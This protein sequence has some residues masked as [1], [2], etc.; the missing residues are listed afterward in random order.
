MPSHT[1]DPIREK[2]RAIAA[3]DYMLCR[4]DI[5]WMLELMKKK[6]AEKD[7]RLLDLPQPRLLDSFHRFAEA[8]LMLINQKPVGGDEIAAIKEWM[9][10]TL[11]EW[12]SPDPAD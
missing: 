8:A 1:P 11:S 10:Q 5:V 6:V 9:R 3:P 2:L 12:V 4:G 7:P